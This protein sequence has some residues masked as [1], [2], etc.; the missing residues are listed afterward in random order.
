MSDW[1]E[2]RH[3]GRRS[4]PF[5]TGRPVLNGAPRP[6]AGAGALFF[7]VAVAIGLAVPGRAGEGGPEHGRR[8]HAALQPAPCLGVTIYAPYSHSNR[9]ASAETP[10]P[11]PPGA[12]DTP[13]RCTPTPGAGV[14][15]AT[16]GGPSST[17][18]GPTHTPTATVS[19]GTPTV[20]TTARATG[21]STPGGPGET[22]SPS[23][24]PGGPTLTPSQTPSQTPD[25][26]PGGPGQTATPTAGGPG[27]SATP[28]ASHTP[29]PTATFTPTIIPVPAEGILGLQLFESDLAAIHDDRLN[30]AGSTWA[31]TRLL[32][33]AAEPS[34]DRP[35]EWGMSDS[36]VG[37][38]AVQELKG[39]VSIY[40]WPSWAAETDCGPL[41]EAGLARYERFLRAAVE[42]YDGDGL[43]DV[44]GSPR[45][46]H[47][48]I[49][50]EPDFSP[51][52]GAGLGEASY[53]SCFGDDPE[54][55]AELLIRSHAAI[56]AADPT[57]VILFGGVAYDRF[58]DY[59]DLD[60]GTAA[61]PF[62]H[63][64]VRT[65]LGALAD[66]HADEPGYPFFDM[67]GF[68]NY[69]DFRDG[70]DGAGGL[71]PEIVGKA[72]RFREEQ[73]VDPG[74]FDFTETPLVSTEVGIASAPSDAWT[75]RS[76][77][78]QAAYAAQVAI[79][80]LAAGLRAMIWYTATDYTGGDCGN[81]YSW[82]MLGLM[83]SEWVAAAA[84]ACPEDP[85]PEY[86]PAEP[87]ER[88]PAYS[89]F[90]TA[91]RV[92]GEAAYLDQ[93]STAELGVAGVEA[94]RVELADGRPAIVAFTDHG[95]S[96]GSRRATDIERVLRVDAGLTGEWTGRLRIVDHLGD[97]RVVTGSSV[98]VRLTYRPLYLV[99]EP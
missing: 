19:A 92:I 4:A 11:S 89:A 22:P 1:R 15:S 86:R 99:V 36:M 18:G 54:A 28:T 93:L 62:R 79:R 77:D 31:R 61:G 21:T 14:P 47:W 58:M 78:Y 84:R 96:L 67:I 55:Y 37:A 41:P 30:E 97:E 43:E 71:E 6:W 35:F 46:E 50:N 90:A 95:R 64:F 27:P 70:W 80:G 98:D 81:P 45:I 39:I 17:P 23:V 26:T 9:R 33:A 72:A 44:P 65:V 63:D 48:E 24:T 73:L 13:R 91:S 34:E 25:A 12:T 87:W 57:A 42:R 74:R 40:Q 76:E 32:W 94:H 29:P 52:A 8:A 68:H 56:R 53:G 60:P 16:P 75:L 7:A 85:L 69:N 3:P 66:D 51:V 83:R 10:T 49:G 5:N 2:A 38:I 59:P 88:K 82:L 20:T